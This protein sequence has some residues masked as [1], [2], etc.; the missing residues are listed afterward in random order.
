MSTSREPSFPRFPCGFLCKRRVAVPPGFP[1]GLTAYH[2]WQR[3]GKVY[4]II[5]Q[6]ATFL[7][8]KAAWP[9]KNPMPG[10]SAR[11]GIFSGQRGDSFFF[12]NSFSNST[13]PKIRST[14]SF[15]VWYS[16][17]VFLACLNSS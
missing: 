11:H 7:D 5:R 9:Q 15:A 3:P 16:T 14:L 1:E 12:S 13:V 6:I 4:H 10:Y 17:I 8:K 2:Q